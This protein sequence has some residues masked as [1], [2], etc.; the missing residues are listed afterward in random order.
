M[1]Y[2]LY[3]EIIERALREDIGNGDLTTKSIFGDET[4]EGLIFVKEQG[5]LAGIFIAAEVFA[6]IDKDIDFKAMHSD[7]TQISAGEC[8]AHI[9][10]KITSILTAERVALN[11]LQRMS[12]IATSTKK[13]VDLIK[14]THARIADTRKTTPGLRILEKYSVRL[15]GGINHRFNLSDLILIKDNHIKGAGSLT[16][17]V[18]RT[19]KNKGFAVKIE[20]ETANLAQ[21]NEALDCKADIIMLDNMS[22]SDMAAAVKLASGK[23]L[24]EASGGITYDRLIEVANTGVDIISLG[25]LTSS[26]PCLDMSLL[27]R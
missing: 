5:V 1:E 11:F 12:G 26:V 16:E 25:Y 22:T 20:V 13:A 27:L 21:V 6:Q 19:R 7:G 24:I 9:R 23:A 18:L 2:L 14:H 4:G 3:R 8:I 17:V 15:G 10:G